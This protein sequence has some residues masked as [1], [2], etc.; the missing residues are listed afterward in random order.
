MG[1]KQFKM[2]Q[3]FHFR[4]TSYEK[5]INVGEDKIQF[6]KDFMDEVLEGLYSIA[7][8]EGHVNKF[9]ETER[10]YNGS[11]GHIT[12]LC[13]NLVIGTGKINC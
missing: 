13:R 8:T 2:M 3:M 11:L 1:N 5:V 7:E 9:I 6:S 12:G 4:R 10:S